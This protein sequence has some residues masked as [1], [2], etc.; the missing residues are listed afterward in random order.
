MLTAGQLKSIRLSPGILFTFSCLSSKYTV[1]V[2]YFLSFC[3]YNNSPV[4]V[5]RDINVKN[6]N[7]FTRNEEVVFLT[8]TISTQRNSHINIH[9]KLRL[10][11]I[12][13][14]MFWNNITLLKYYRIQLIENPYS[15]IIY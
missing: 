6:L 15:N 9:S 12:R 7:N 1:F 14:I 5:V 4:N 11:K 8:R 10:T 2:R 3:A 13:M